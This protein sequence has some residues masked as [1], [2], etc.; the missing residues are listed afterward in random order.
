M[1][2]L[3][4]TIATAGTTAFGTITT[5][6]AALGSAFSTLG[7][8]EFLHVGFQ[9]F[10]FGIGEFAVLVCIILFHDQIVTKHHHWITTET[11]IG[12]TFTTSSRA[13]FATAG[14]IFACT[15]AIL[16]TIFT[17]GLLFV[18]IKLSVAILIELLEHFG[19]AFFHF[20]SDFRIVFVPFFAHGLAFFFA[21]LAV[22][23]LVELLE[24]FIATGCTTLVNFSFHGGFFFIV[25]LAVLIGVELFQNKLVTDDEHAHLFRVHIRTLTTLAVLTTTLTALVLLS[26][27]IALGSIGWCRGFILG[28]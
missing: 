16:L 27:V 19:M 4:T 26:F 10:F 23:I 20:I 18:V 12:A 14:T 1:F 25:E 24:H 28:E 13:T 6:L 22:A 9:H 7:I 17:H 8:H 3:T 2:G 11:A 5:T 21:D 15:R